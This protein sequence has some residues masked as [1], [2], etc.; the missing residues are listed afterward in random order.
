MKAKFLHHGCPLGWLLTE[1][2]LCAIV[3]SKAH[4]HP[5]IGTTN[6]PWDAPWSQAI[7]HY[8]D[9]LRAPFSGEDDRVPAL[10]PSTSRRGEKFNA[11]MGRRCG[12]ADFLE[13]PSDVYGAVSWYA[14]PPPRAERLCW[15]LSTHQ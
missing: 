2:P 10:T 3:I 15:R 7:N 9:R 8:V 5:D 1:F 12:V 13:K 11:G 6:T 14:T 4:H